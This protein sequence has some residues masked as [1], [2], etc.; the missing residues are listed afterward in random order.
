M[1]LFRGRGENQ[2]DRLEK[3]LVSLEKQISAATSG[4]ETQFLN[5]AGDLCVEFG[6]TERALRY[7]GRA[8]DAYL[9]SGRFGAA[10][11]LCRKVL[12]IEPQVVRA[13]CTL[14][15]LALGR[16]S[17]GES[18]TAIEDYVRAAELT[19]QAEFALKQLVIMA[20]ATPEVEIRESIAKHLLDLGAVEQ[21]DRLFGLVFQEQNGLL[22]PPEPDKSR[23]WATLLKAALMGPKD[24][25]ERSWTQLGEES[26][27]LPSL[28]DREH[29]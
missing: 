12:Q 16:G 1:S 21:A 11:V 29:P 8:I 4:Y 14:A 10:E 19:Q 7:Y 24:L 17:V 5:R 13:R 2:G 15:W 9:E 25:Q 3:E 28:K 26:D 18:R 6:Q 22:P 27:D 23:L 20:E